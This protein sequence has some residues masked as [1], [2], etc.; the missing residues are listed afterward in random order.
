MRAVRGT[1][2]KP[3]HV[4]HTLGVRHASLQYCHSSTSKQNTCESKATFDSALASSL[5]VPL[6]EATMKRK[7]MAHE[8]SKQLLE[9]PSRR[10]PERSLRCACC[11]Q[12]RKRLRALSAE[13]DQ[14]RRGRV[15]EHS[16]ACHMFSEQ[17]PY[18]DSEF[19]CRE[20]EEPSQPE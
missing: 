12:R 10:A 20:F 19:K 17:T 3:Y 7:F 11:C 18:T 4:N 6:I 9:R 5:W 16:E 14:G 1:P 2:F 15:N 13:Q 8:L